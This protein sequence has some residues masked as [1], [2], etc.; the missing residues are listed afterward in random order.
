[1]F[2]SELP[3]LF[4]GDADVQ[5]VSEAMFD[6]FEYLVLR[7]R[8]GLLKKDFKTPLGKVSYHIPCHSRVQNVGQKTREVLEW[9]PQTTV[10]TVERCS[11][12]D[13]TWG[14]KTEFYAD[15]DEDRQ[16]GIPARWGRA[17]RITSAPIVRSPAGRYCRASSR[18]SR[19]R[20]RRSC[21]R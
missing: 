8:D 19:R 18:R 7:D 6:P 16:A 14:V 5:A 12:H 10:T 1:M 17:I 4:A 20:A 11:G 3:L 2:K 13:G 9:V 15:V 21:I